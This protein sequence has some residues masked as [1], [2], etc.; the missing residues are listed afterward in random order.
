MAESVTL[1]GKAIEDYR[2]I[3]KDAMRWNKLQD[4][5]IFGEIHNDGKCL[6]LYDVFSDKPIPILE[7]IIDQA[8]K[9]E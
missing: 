3:L 4:C 6:Y 7:E 9:D 8:I 5:S 1:E 2:E